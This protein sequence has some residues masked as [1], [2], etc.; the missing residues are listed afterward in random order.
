MPMSRKLGSIQRSGAT[1][2]YAVEGAGIPVLVVGSAVFYPRT[3]SRR[4]RE[5]C[6]LAFADLR[7]F[8]EGFA[9]SR[10]A[11]VSF[12]AYAEDIDHLRAAIGFD[13]AVIVGHSHHGCIALEYARRYPKRVT[14]AVLIGAPPV[15]VERTLAAGAA[16][17]EEHASSE[18]KAVL[19]RNRRSLEAGHPDEAAAGDAFVWRYV[20]DG[21][22]YW[23]DPHFDAAPLWDGVPIDMEAISAFRGLF[24]D[25]ELRWDSTGMP[26]PVLA[27]TGQYDYVVPP[28]L[29]D[30]AIPK[31]PGITHVRFDDSGHTPQLEE[32]ERFDDLL[33]GWLERT[34]GRCE[35]AAR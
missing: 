12:D 18:R 30:A 34:H 35:R 27:V 14:H 28:P 3:F 15:S 26:A 24:T 16:Y 4:L 22:R 10:V 2:R 21:P 32:P 33:I 13:K 9:G 29:W 31:L 8:G 19:E 23:Y 5:D 1:L 6:T 7:H 20:A 11:E 17:W 25:Y